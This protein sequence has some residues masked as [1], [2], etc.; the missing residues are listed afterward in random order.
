MSSVGVSLQSLVDEGRPSMRLHL[1]K[2]TW[3]KSEM[4]KFVIDALH[5]QF[6]V[7]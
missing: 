7:C 3:T 1:R 2:I 6:G 5:M 4:V